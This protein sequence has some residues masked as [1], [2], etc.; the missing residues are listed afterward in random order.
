MAGRPW[1]T[2]DGEIGLE[3]SLLEFQKA[4]LRL[5]IVEDC[6]EL[7]A[8]IGGGCY[9]QIAAVRPEHGRQ[10]LAC[11]DDPLEVDDVAS[12]ERDVARDHSGSGAGG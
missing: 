6:V 3:A 12:S 11:L 1:K 9:D 5:E 2:T 10:P 7:C 4:E 8:S